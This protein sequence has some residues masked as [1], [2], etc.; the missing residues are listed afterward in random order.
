M[1][2]NQPLDVAR[3]ASE[4]E[5][6]PYHLI[7]RYTRRSNGRRWERH[8][9]VASERR[10]YYPMYEYRASFDS[11]AGEWRYVKLIEVHPPIEEPSPND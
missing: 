11:T 4:Q 9:A 1:N 8:F 2:F 10:A 3:Y 5:G 7:I 6:V